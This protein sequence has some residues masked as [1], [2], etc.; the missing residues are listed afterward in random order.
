M[1]NEKRRNLKIYLW[2]RVIPKYT[3]QGINELEDE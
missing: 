3:G 2:K 1:Q